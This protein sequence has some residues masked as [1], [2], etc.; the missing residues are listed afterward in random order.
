LRCSACSCSS[1]TKAS[2]STWRMSGVSRVLGRVLEPRNHSGAHR[3][4]HWV[5]AHGGWTIHVTNS[6][7]GCALLDL[8]SPFHWRLRKQRKI[9]RKMVRQ[10]EG[11]LLGYDFECHPPDKLE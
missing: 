11:L 1:G 9:F 10:Q 6:R 4:F 7:L 5:R 3:M 8:F 2:F